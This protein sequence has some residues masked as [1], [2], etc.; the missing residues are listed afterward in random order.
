MHCLPAEHQRDLDRL[1]SYY[2]WHRHRIETVTASVGRFLNQKQEEPLRYLDVGGGT[3]A[4]TQAIMESLRERLHR[5]VPSETT[6]SLDGDEG[7]ESLQKDKPLTFQHKDLE[8]DWDIRRGGFDLVTLLDVIE[9]VQNPIRLLERAKSQMDSQGIGVITVPA[10]GF[11]FSQ[12]DV[13]LG[14]KKRYTAGLLRQECELAGLKVLWASYLFSYMFPPVLAK[15]IL[16]PNPKESAEFPEVPEF[17][18]SF[19]LK[20]G[21]VER[22]LARWVSI[23]FGTSVAAVV[24]PG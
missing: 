1:P 12:W 21:S 7:L 8:T 16:F 6:V 3:G 15:R 20:A 5:T 22:A 2:W 11:L 18:N 14:H 4:T 17:F 19:L 9:H 10:Y 24:R 13:A 23:P